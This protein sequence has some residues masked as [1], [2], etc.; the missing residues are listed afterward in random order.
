MG[1]GSCCWRDEAG[2]VTERCCEK[3]YYHLT[4]RDDGRQ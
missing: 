3:L 4:D 2:E 1:L